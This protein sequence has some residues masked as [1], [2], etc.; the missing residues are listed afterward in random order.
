MW[1]K[2]H[3][4]IWSVTD[5]NFINWTNWNK[6]FS[7]NVSSLDDRLA[8]LSETTAGQLELRHFHVDYRKQANGVKT[9]MDIL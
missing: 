8:Y 9:N 4:L 6:P 1:Y 2:C 7:P 5:I 3:V